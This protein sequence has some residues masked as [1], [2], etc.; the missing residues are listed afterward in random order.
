MIDYM[1]KEIFALCIDLVEN[2]RMPALPRAYVR[3]FELGTFAMGDMAPDVRF[4][5][6]GSRRRPDLKMVRGA[7]EALRS[8]CDLPVVVVSPSLDYWQKEWLVSRQLPFIQ[9]GRNAFPPFSGLAVRDA[10]RTKRPSS[11]S[12]Q[13]Q[14]IVVNLIEGNWDIVSVGD[15][16]KRVGRSRAS[17]SK[18]LTEIEAICP[19]AVRRARRCSV[20]TGCERRSFWTAPSR[21]S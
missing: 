2:A 3:A 14:R 15:V 8:E 7:V 16:A 12:P 17:A 21:T 11:L 18:Y 20:V 6:V 13:A 19:E 1:P 9:D 5:A 4:V 10:S